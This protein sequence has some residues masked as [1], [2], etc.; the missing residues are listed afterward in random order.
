MGTGSRNRAAAVVAVTAALASLTGT[1]LRA[2]AAL[3]PPKVIA[4]GD[5]AGGTWMVRDRLSGKGLT[6]SHYTVGAINFPCST[7]RALA[8]KLTRR[9][10]LGPGPTAL[11][12]GFMCLTG[13]PKGRQLEHGGCSVGTSQVLM[14][15]ATIKSFKWQACRTIPQR[16]EHP[17]CTTRALP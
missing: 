16:H 10:S 15:T 3:A 8:A 14:P 2:D 12:P 17:S 6:G 5:I 13:I 1:A 9:R 11:L 4:C 7:A